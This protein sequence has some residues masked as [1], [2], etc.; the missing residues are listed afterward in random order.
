MLA[1][2]SKQ[3][4]LWKIVHARPRSFGD[5]IKVVPAWYAVTAMQQGGITEDAWLISARVV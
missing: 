5:G 4:P 3:R 2:E 1:T